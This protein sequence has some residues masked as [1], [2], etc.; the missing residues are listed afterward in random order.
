MRADWL[1]LDGTDIESAGMLE[2]EDYAKK[3]AVK[4]QLARFMKGR[5]VLGAESCLPRP[6]GSPDQRRPGT[7]RREGPMNGNYDKP[8]TALTGSPV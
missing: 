8:R 6:Q 4:Q 3:I 1:V 2:N 7:L 5:L